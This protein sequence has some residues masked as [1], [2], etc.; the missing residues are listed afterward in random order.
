MSFGGEA[1]IPKANKY[2]R[3]CLVRQVKTV[4]KPKQARKRYIQVLVEMK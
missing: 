3:S 2:V 1:I 4:V